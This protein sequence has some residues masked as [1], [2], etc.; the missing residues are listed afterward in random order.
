[1]NYPTLYS[2]A[3]SNMYIPYRFSE[4]YKIIDIRT[5][6]RSIAQWVESEVFHVHAKFA[7]YSYSFV[8][9]LPNIV[10]QGWRFFVLLMRFGTTDG[11]NPYGKCNSTHSC[12]PVVLGPYNHPQWLCMKAFSLMLTLISLVT[13]D[14]ICS[15]CDSSFLLVNSCIYINTIFVISQACCLTFRSFI[16]VFQLMFRN[17]LKLFSFSWIVGY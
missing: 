9:L 4:T 13:L 17:I 3:L 14:E 5:F 7:K 15:C 6:C 16:I 11:F 1:V 8:I 10:V 2:F 12:W